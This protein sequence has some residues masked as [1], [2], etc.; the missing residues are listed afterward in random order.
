MA[1]QEFEVT[2]LPVGKDGIVNPSDVEKAITKNTILISVMHANNEVGTVQPIS[3]IG[4][5]A[6]ERSV[7]FHT[8]AVQTF[9]HLEIDV[10]KMGIDLLSLSAHKLYGPKGAGALYI[11]KETPIVPFL[12][13]GAQEKGRRS[14]TLNVPGIVGLGKAAE[15][16][17]KEMKN[18]HARILNLRNRL[19]DNILQKIEGAHLNGHPDKR[20]PNNLNISF[21]SVEGEALLMNLD[22][23]GISSS[24]GSACSSGSTEPSHVLTALWLSPELSRGSLRLTLGRFTTEEEVDRVAEVLARTVAHLRSLSPFGKGT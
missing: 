10:E 15:I 6:K 2:F 14:S 3:E 1:S 24:S 11:R 19:H 20:L 21:E 16:A 8:D 23:E 17:Q 12:H 13:G 18:E 5:I 4:A 9:G 7:L 22:L